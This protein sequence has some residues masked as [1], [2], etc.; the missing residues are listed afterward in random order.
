MSLAPCGIVVLSPTKRPSRSLE[1]RHPCA[2]LSS[3]S[4]FGWVVQEDLLVMHP[5]I[6]HWVEAAPNEGCR[7]H[8]H[9]AVW[10]RLSWVSP[11]LLSPFL[12]TV[13]LCTHITSPRWS[14]LMGKQQEVGESLWPSDQPSDARFFG[15]IPRQ[16]RCVHLLQSVCHPLHHLLLC[17][18]PLPNTEWSNDSRIANCWRGH[19]GRCIW[20]WCGRGTCVALPSTLPTPSRSPLISRL[21]RRRHRFSSEPVR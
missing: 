5:T 8:T 15:R 16:E 21:P 18:L 14:P 7:T 19:L 3:S 20:N 1:H 10:K 6:P 4:F 12:L 17:I 11:V 13:R 2:P 9:C